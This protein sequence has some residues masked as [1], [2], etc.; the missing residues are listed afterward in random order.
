MEISPD[1]LILWEWGAFKLNATL[2]FTWVVM[3]LLVLTSWLVTRRLSAEP[4]V[5]PAQNFLEMVVEAIANQIREASQQEPRQYLPF[6]GTLF[7][8]IASCNLL[9]V[10]PGYRP[11]TGSLST[12]VALAL[13]VFVAVP[14][15]G[16][17]KRGVGDYLRNYIR[18]TPFMLPFNI[19]GEFSRTLA[20][21]VRLFGNTLSGNMIVAILIS[22]VPL[23][24][25]IVMQVLGL[26]IGLIQA[27]VFAILTMVYIASATSAGGGRPSATQPSEEGST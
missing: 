18:P 27:Y 17:L 12:T 4:E 16:I 14:F 1:N 26:L 20:M 5:P 25:P 8:L 3:G 6:V 13:C 24:F 22:L 10:V 11:P 2:L 19:I 23:F 21:A 9:S 7:L 15:Y